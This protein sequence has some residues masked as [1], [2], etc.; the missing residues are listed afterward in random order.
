GNK[1][2]KTPIK[3]NGCPFP[4]T[5]NLMSAIRHL[6]LKSRRRTMW[7]DAICINQL[8]LEER[9]SQVKQIR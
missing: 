3:L 2:R 8:N 5:I 4:V 7:I 1:D 6:G 9:T